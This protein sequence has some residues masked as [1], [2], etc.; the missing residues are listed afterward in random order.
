MENIEK[1][2]VYRFKDYDKYKAAEQT[3]RAKFGNTC[4]D[5]KEWKDHYSITIYSNCP[6]EASQI[7]RKY[8]GK[9]SS[10]IYKFTNDDNYNT[11]WSNLCNEFGYDKF[12]YDNCFGTFC[13][14]IQGIHLY[15]IEIYDNC[16]VPYLALEICKKNGGED[17]NIFEVCKNNK[18]LK[19]TS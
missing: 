13:F 18:N 16:P 19:T 2:A 6:E 15:Y 12:G 9:A 5:P 7:C 3:L 17:E 4:Y 14:D 11:A 10:A 1:I 8:G